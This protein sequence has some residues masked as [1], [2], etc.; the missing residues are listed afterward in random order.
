M[1]LVVLLHWCCLRQ[2]QTPTAQCSDG[3]GI[4]FSFGEIVKQMRQRIVPY[5]QER[6][7]LVAKLLQQLATHPL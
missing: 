1:N 4:C 2:R 7:F 5:R 6:S 3:P